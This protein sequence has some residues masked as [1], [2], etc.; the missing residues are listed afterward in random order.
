MCIVMK[1][2]NTRDWKK[3]SRGREGGIDKKLNFMRSEFP[4][5]PRKVLVIETWSSEYSLADP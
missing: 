2:H 5:N 3:R 4:L 1:G